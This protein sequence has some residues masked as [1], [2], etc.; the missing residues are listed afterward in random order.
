MAAFT[1]TPRNAMIDW[2]TGKTNPAA[3]GTRYITV[4]NGD[5]QGAGAE[6]I[7]TLTGSANRQA[8]TASM[9]AAAAGVAAST[10]SIVFTTAAVGSATVNFVAI[11]DALTAGNLLGSVAVT[12]KTPAIGD[13]LSILAPNLTVSIA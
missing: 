3:I 11:Y 4:Y 7:S 8:I 6:V 5:P 10:A 13:S 2:Y 1:V 9:G 12:S